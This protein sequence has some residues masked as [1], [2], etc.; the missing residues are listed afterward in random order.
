VKFFLWYRATYMVPQETRN[1]RVL[2]WVERDWIDCSRLWKGTSEFQESQNVSC[3]SR[4]W[5]SKCV[6]IVPRTASSHTSR[7]RRKSPKTMQFGSVVSSECECS[8][9]S[10]YRV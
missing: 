8:H 1:T 3:W 2:T 9:R 5:P 6:Q 4:W 7:L 10:S